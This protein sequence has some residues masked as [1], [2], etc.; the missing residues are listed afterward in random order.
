MYCV[1]SPLIVVTVYVVVSE[2]MESR[3][4]VTPYSMILLDEKKQKKGMIE[5]YVIGGENRGSLRP[6]FRIGGIEG[7]P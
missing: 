6:I 4:L 3:N 5:L 7:Y 2:R 1:C